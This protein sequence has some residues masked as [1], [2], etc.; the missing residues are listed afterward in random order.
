MIPIFGTFSKRKRYLCFA[1]TKHMNVVLQRRERNG[2]KIRCIAPVPPVKGEESVG[3]V[4]ARAV[5]YTMMVSLGALEQCVLLFMY[6]AQN[7]D[8][9]FSS[10]LF[11]YF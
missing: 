9:Y 1:P 11:M 4:T 3:P 2:S 8:M 6:L 10:V 7:E 5:C